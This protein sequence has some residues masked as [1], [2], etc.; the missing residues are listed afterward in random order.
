MKSIASANGKT[1]CLIKS[2]SALYF[3]EYFDMENGLKHKDYKINHSDLFVTIADSDA[4]L[5]NND[6]I[7]HA[8]DTLSFKLGN[9][10]NG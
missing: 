8:P 2:G 10:Y 7:D 4:F 5:Y 6:I 3:R 9:T 1:G